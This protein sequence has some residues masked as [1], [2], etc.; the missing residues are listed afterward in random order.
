MTSNQDGLAPGEYPVPGAQTY[1]DVGADTMV[2]SPTF[3]AV[4]VAEYQAMVAL[5]AAVSGSRQHAEDIAQDAMTKLDQNWTKVQSYGKPG[6]WLRRV[7]INLALS[8]KRR[9][10]SEAKALLR[11]GK[12]EPELP[13]NP[14]EHEHI[15]A[16][17]GK[18]PKMQRAVVSLH[19]LEDRSLEDIGEILE[20]KPATARVHL[21]R[22]RQSLQEN[23]APPGVTTST[24]ATP[25]PTNTHETEQEAGR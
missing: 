24:H 16:L 22:A 9:L 19:F 20:I 15:W 1:R 21:H 18:L 4:F 12:P 2:G 14:S 11:I 8:Q 3:E 5:A 17:I 23:L 25:Q 7:T 6:A 10:R 13:V